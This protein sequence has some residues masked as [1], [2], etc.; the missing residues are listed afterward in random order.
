M[1]VKPLF[2][3]PILA[4]NT[5]SERDLLVQLPSLP[6]VIDDAY[7][8]WITLSGGALATSSLLGGMIGM[9]WG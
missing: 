9:G 2:A 7:L 1:L 8:G 5:A 3:I 4:A 6:Q